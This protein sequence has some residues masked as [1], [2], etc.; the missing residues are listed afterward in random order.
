MCSVAIYA[1]IDPRDGAIRYVGKSR[2]PA[3]RLREHVAESMAK[4]THKDR[5]IQQAL[6]AGFRPG[7]EILELAPGEAAD[8]RERFWIAELRQR[9]ER[10]VNET[11]GGDGITMT[12]AIRARIAASNRKPKS[13]EHAAAI[14]RGR[15]GIEFSS[16]HREA[17]KRAGATE[18]LRRK[19]REAA[20]ARWANPDFRAK[21][22]AI[23]S[24]V[25]ARPDVRAKRS[26]ALK[27]RRSHGD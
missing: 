12:P 19:R 4:R 27:G 8:D 7:M 26:A 14:S 16:E 11:D 3:H 17:L 13:P 23:Q 2:R 15:K 10:L 21:M 20:K 6:V 5:W 24:V 9:G 22:R 1:L 18:E 25:Q